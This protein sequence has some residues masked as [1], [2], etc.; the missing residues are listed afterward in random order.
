YNL[1]ALLLL[2]PTNLS[3][4]AVQVSNGTDTSCL[5][6]AS[7]PAR[8]SAVSSSST[9]IPASSASQSSTMSNASERGSSRPNPSVIAGAVV[10]A[11][12]L[13][14]GVLT[15]YFCVYRRSLRR[16]HPSHNRPLMQNY[17]QT[18]SGSPTILVPSVMEPQEA[19]QPRRDGILPRD[20][21]NQP[22]GPENP[23]TVQRLREITK[24]MGF[25]EERM[26]DHGLSADEP[27]PGYLA[28]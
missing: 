8:P 24:R 25:I 28:H 13:I 2:A 7:N 15:A 17:T 26:Q 19:A 3:Q 12:T 14:T 22:A 18:D 23:E 20:A 9:D 4:F 21:S 16:K 6:S 5:T 1:V 10:G 27:P 11:L